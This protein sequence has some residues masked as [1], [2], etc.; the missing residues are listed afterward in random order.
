[1]F[2]LDEVASRALYS[3]PVRLACFA[4]AS[5]ASLAIAACSDDEPTPQNLVFVSY[6]G[7][8]DT[9]TAQIALSIDLAQ[10]RVT[11]TSGLAFT[12]ALTAEAHAQIDIAESQVEATWDPAEPC[13]TCGVYPESF[14]FNSDQ[15]PV[16]VMFG[17]VG[18]GTN[19]EQLRLVV[20]ELILELRDCRGGTL[21]QQCFAQP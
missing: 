12:A 7:W 2:F 17:H 15:G 10:D 18:D 6:D 3:S 4:L 14:H 21:I 1:V 11:L 13:P 16:A 8:N 20:D 9:G 19:V 5:L